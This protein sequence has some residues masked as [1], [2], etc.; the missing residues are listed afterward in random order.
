MARSNLSLTKICSTCKVEK[1]LDA[2]GKRTQAKDGRRYQCKECEAK[3]FDKYRIKNKK[4]LAEKLAKWQKENPEKRRAGQ[5]RLTRERKDIVCKAKEKPCA[6]CGVEYP[7]A[8]MHFDH[9]R[10]VKEFSLSSAHRFSIKRIEAEIAKCEIR[11]PTC[12]S[13]RHYKA[14]EGEKSK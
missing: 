5:K 12:H 3:S 10:G 9:V 11:C 2:F 7:S 4:T 1:N 6:D 14:Q 8:I 13:L